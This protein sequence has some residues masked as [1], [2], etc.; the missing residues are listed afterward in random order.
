MILV[1]V[2]VNSLLPCN[3]TPLITQSRVYLLLSMYGDQTL[4]PMLI[5][6][7]AMFGSVTGLD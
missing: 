1:V 6:V 2:V 5:S 3:T 4:L 7:S